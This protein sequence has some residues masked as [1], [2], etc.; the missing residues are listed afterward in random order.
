MYEET[1]I[2]SEQGLSRFDAHAQPVPCPIC[3]GKANGLQEKGFDI[4]EC[5]KCGFFEIS[6]L[7]KE[8]MAKTNLRSKAISSLIADVKR[9]SSRN[10]PGKF[11]IYELEKYIMK[12]LNC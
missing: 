5:K 7:F 1:G 2:V 6:D 11:T 9:F 3:G 10:S 12:L 8:N 4:I